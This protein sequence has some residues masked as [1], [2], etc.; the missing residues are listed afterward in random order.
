MLQ[1]MKHA[2]VKSRACA[3]FG[4]VRCLSASREIDESGGAGNVTPVD[5]KVK[6]DVGGVWKSK[7]PGMPLDES[8]I[9]SVRTNCS[10][11]KKR[12]DEI[13]GRRTVKKMNQAAWVL[14]AINCIDLTTLSGDDT[15]G[16]VQRLCAKA[17]KPVRSDILSSLDLPDNFITT[18]AVC[19]Y[20]KR[21][22]DAVEALEGTGVSVASVAT[23]FPSGQITHKHKLQEIQQCVV[24]GANEVRRGGEGMQRTECLARRNA[25]C[26]LTQSFAFFVVFF[27]SLSLPACTKI[28]VVISRDY[29]LLSDWSSL[30]SEVRSFR[31]ACGPDVKMKVILATGELST[32]TS[33]YKA[34]LACMM[35]GADFIKTSTG[36]EKVNANLP[37]TLCML[38]AIREYYNL[39]NYMVGY[40]PAGGI[41][42]SKDVLSHISMV[43]EE[44]G[45]AWVDNEFFRVGASSLLNDCERQLY[46]CAHGVYPAG[47][48]MPSA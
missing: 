45:D 28:D 39:T 46:H 48:Y 30:Y 33:V 35:A 25:G 32:F 13:G 27:L 12:A 15:R 21:V 14:R 26:F 22:R 20:P 24:D 43:K 3:R 29:A 2:A 17:A 40:K 44:L 18:A 1:V 34:S 47:Y 37:T 11:L 41:S 6:K 10:G 7:N 38:R 31:E 23:G 42:T 9:E 16:N 19:V 36:K 8:L 4:G 5:D